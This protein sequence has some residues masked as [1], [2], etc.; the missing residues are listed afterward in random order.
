M[1]QLLS[2]AADIIA[3]TVRLVSFVTI[4]LVRNSF[5][6]IPIGYAMHRILRATAICTTRLRRYYG[7]GAVVCAAC[8]VL[9]EALALG[10][11]T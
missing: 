3:Q 5:T 7:Y 9:D 11:L 8:A 4:H 1:D 6:D 2:L 10:P